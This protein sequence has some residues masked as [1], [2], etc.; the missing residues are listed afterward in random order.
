MYILILLIFDCNFYWIS[1]ITRVEI[2][3]NDCML[4]FYVTF[5]ARVNNGWFGF[6]ENK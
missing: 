3:L 4:E 6:N 2:F 5:I 1:M